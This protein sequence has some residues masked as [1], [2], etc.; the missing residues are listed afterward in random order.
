MF[1]LGERGLVYKYSTKLLEVKTAS[2]TKK[3]ALAFFQEYSVHKDNTDIS[4]ACL[5]N[6]VQ[7]IVG[8]DKE[9]AA[10]AIGI[11]ENIMESGKAGQATKEIIISVLPT[12]N[13]P[14]YARE[15]LDALKRLLRK[16]EPV[17]RN[18]PNNGRNMHTLYGI[19]KPDNSP[20]NDV[21]TKYGISKP[22]VPSNQ[23]STKYGVGKCFPSKDNTK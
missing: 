11:F 4:Y 17:V 19:V 7:S 5:V 21:A 15:R 9:Y 2:V 6:S 1:G 18:N 8:N 14:L 20:R 16:R 10:I 23:V 22:R 3:E 13:V 12:L